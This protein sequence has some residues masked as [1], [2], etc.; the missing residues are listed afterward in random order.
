M[1]AA[2]YQ[3][4]PVL[5]WDAARPRWL[6]A[7]RR[8]L[9]ASDVA[10]ILGFSQYTSPWQVWA[11][12][13]DV[14][15]PPDQPSAS[16]DLGNDLEMWLLDRATVLLGQPVTNTAAQLYAHPEHPWRMCSPDGVTADGTV[17][18]EAKTAGLASGYGPPKGWDDGGIPLGY[19][20]Q[21]RWLCH[22]MGWQVVELVALV[23]NMGVVRRTVTRDL[24]VEA[25]LIGQVDDWW[26][27]H[28]IGRVEPP[29]GAADNSVMAEMYPS[30]SGDVVD[31]DGTDA[32]EHWLAYRDAHQR[33]KAAKEDKGA[34]GAALKQLLGDAW[35]GRLDGRLLV[36]WGEKQ[37]HVDYDRLLADLAAAGVTVPNPNSYRNPPGRSLSV[38]D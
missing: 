8:G 20:F 9:G 30:T 25:D 3:P 32:V 33:E 16:A 17:G 11:E 21:C 37:G 35:G 36:T 18:V 15:R 10:A 26:T 38:K 7:R 14:R 13:L 5:G 34:A 29:L 28:I 24:S 1:T 23:A 31:L 4:V 27:K 22:V 12:K 6:A 19:E 2:I